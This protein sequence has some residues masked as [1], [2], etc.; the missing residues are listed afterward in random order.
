MLHTAWKDHSLECSSHNQ[1]VPKKS[2][3]H[4]VLLSPSMCLRSGDSEHHGAGEDLADN[5]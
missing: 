5:C 4:L 1:K 2:H 3:D